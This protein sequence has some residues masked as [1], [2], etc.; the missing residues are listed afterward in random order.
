MAA[1]FSRFCGRAERG[2][3]RAQKRRERTQGKGES[4]ELSLGQ[5]RT[6]GACGLSGSE[7]I[8]DRDGEKGKKD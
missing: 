4:F 8:G 2:W 5:I 6:A 3:I 7:W 1:C